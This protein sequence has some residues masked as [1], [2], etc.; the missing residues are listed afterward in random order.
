MKNSLAE[1]CKS[2]YTAFRFCG[3]FLSLSSFFL[4]PPLAE[5]RN[6]A[7]RIGAGYTSQI[8]QIDGSTLPALDAKYYFSK[9]AAASLGL[10]FDTRSDRSTVAVGSKFF[11]NLFGEKNLIFYTGAG[12]AMISSRGSKMQVSGFLGSE[13]FLTDLPSLGFSFEAGIRGD[14]SRG[15]KF[16]LRTTGDSILTAGIHF[17]F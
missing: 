7:K 5:A 8:A 4:L 15:G 16:S 2:F 17:Y 1:L 10:G 11:Y 9:R 3:L 12:L 14:S 6:L 13:F